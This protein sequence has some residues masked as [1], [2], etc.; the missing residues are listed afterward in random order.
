MTELPP[1]LVIAG[2]TASGKS[3][4]ALAAAEV[5][6]GELI[7]ADA[8]AVYR[9]MDIGTDK[10]DLSARKRA[11]HHLIDILEPDELYSAGEFAR[12][13]GTLINEIRA[14]NRVPIIVG[15][16]HFYIKA[17]IEGLCPTPDRDRAIREKLETAW[18]EDPS[19]VFEELLRVDPAG[20]RRIGAKDR[21]RILRALEVFESSG[22]P[23]SEHWKLQ[24]EPPRYRPLYLAP[25]REREELYARINERVDAMFARG[26]VAEVEALLESGIDP[27][28][29]A[30]KAIGYRELVEMRKQDREITETIEAI[31][32]SSRH[33][34]KRQLTW[35]RNHQ[36]GHLHWVRPL[37]RGGLEDVLDLWSRHAESL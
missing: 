24:S 37:E 35:L 15:G 18:T 20:A 14:R 6:D 21:Q 34:A 27:G 16:T 28:S 22:R 12:R 23:L 10:P 19:K 4:L 33:F 3:S 30:L 8:F 2:P 17:L 13:A 29:H 9:G 31:K 5:L 25:H 26:F 11:P 36:G 7:S 32:T 1:L